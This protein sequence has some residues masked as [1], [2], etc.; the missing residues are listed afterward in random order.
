MQRSAIP[1]VANPALSLH[2]FQNTE[3]DSVKLIKRDFQIIDTHN[4]EI[5][6]HTTLLQLLII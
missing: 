6:L 3:R 5:P 1:I 2:A 4:Y